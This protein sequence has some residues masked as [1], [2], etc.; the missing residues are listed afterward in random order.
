MSQRRVAL[1]LSTSALCALLVFSSILVFQLAVDPFG[2]WGSPVVRGWNN[3][4]VVM[5][6]TNRIFKPYQYMERKPEVVFLGTSHVEW[7]FPPVWPGTPSSEVYNFGLGTLSVFEVAEYVKLFLEPPLPRVVVLE[8]DPV[9][10]M[11]DREDFIPGFSIER[12]DALKSFFSPL[13]YA[14]RLKELVFN[15]DAIRKS[16]ETTEESR[17]HPGQRLYDDSGYYIR[18]GE[19]Q[20]PTRSRF[21]SRIWRYARGYYRAKQFSEDGVSIFKNVISSLREQGVEVVLFSSP[22][23]V[24]VQMIINSQGRW[25]GYEAIKR[26]MAGFTPFWDFANVN[27]LTVDKNN[28]TDG[29]HFAGDVGRLVVNKISGANPTETTGGAL[30]GSGVLLTAGNASREL[31]RMRKDLEDWEKGHSALLKAIRECEKTGDRKAF[32]AATKAIYRFR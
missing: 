14:L 20:R 25:S 22:L 27:P 16:F 32:D 13:G 29:S 7:G 5:P 12:L 18:Q 4:K 10:F 3:A 26:E 9:A 2:V 17:K 15:F 24:D 6:N 23:F 11:Q 21:Q 28:Y 30:A 1:W 19:G 31:K 8:M